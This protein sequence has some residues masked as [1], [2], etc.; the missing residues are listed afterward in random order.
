MLS[1]PSSFNLNYATLL[2]ARAIVMQAFLNYDVFL[3]GGGAL[4]MLSGPSPFIYDFMQGILLP[5]TK[6][7][8]VF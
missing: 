7:C 8:K 2:I 3:H 1:A 5:K 6:L 4:Q